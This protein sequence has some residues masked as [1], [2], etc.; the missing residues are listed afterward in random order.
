MAGIYGALHLKDI[1]K[2]SVTILYVF[3]GSKNSIFNPDCL[4]GES[5]EIKELERRLGLKYSEG[6]I[7]PDNKD[8]SEYINKRMQ[9]NYVELAFTIGKLRNKHN[10]KI[11]ENKKDKIENAIKQLIDIREKTIKVPALKTVQE[12]QSFVF[13]AI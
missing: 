12:N 3:S 13:N 10:I 9:F 1:Y 4:E 5:I 6:D 7:E 2:E 8:L 11:I